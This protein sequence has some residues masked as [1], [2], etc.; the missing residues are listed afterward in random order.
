MPKTEEGAKYQKLYTEE[1]VLAALQAIEDGMSQR[2]AAKTYNVPRQTLQFRLSDKFNNKTSLGP[3]PYLTNDE[4]RLLEEWILDGCRKGYPVRKYDIQA[5]VKEFLDANI[6][7]NPFKNNFPGDGWYKAFLKRH[8]TLTHRTA[9]AVTAASAQISEDN[10][11]RWFTSVEDY[12]REKNLNDILLDP[13][14]MFNGDE[15]CFVL[16]PKNTKVLA[17]KGAKNVYEVDSSQAKTTL[18]V[19][20]T[21]SAAGV[22]TNPM[23]IYPYKRIPTN[24][25]NSVPKGWGLGH[26]LELK[27]L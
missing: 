18:T 1:N 11:R 7:D 15:T 25:V 24:I 26:R 20:F 10:I 4:E 6:R 27:H 9:E 21:F 8:P 13:S 23:I 5:S 14:R 12:L 17:P 2:L 3:N 22:V 19:M 16:C